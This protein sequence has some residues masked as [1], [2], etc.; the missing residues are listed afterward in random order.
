VLKM[1]QVFWGFGG[2]REVQIVPLLTWPNMN[3]TLGGVGSIETRNVVDGNAE[4][5]H[6]YLV[7][8]TYSNW[9]PGG[10]SGRNIE[11]W[12]YKSFLLSRTWS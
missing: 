5:C 6:P 9:N 2:E 4:S 11:A 12:A 1:Q 10:W 8:G 7:P 3:L